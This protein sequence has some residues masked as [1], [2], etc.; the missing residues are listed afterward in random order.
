MS[1][2]GADSGRGVSG[3]L[4][5]MYADTTERSTLLVTLSPVSTSVS[6]A[7]IRVSTFSRSGC[8]REG[9]LLKE[10]LLVGGLEGAGEE[11]AEW[12]TAEPKLGS[13]KW[14][15]QCRPRHWKAS[16]C[17]CSGSSSSSQARGREAWE[18]WCPLGR[19]ATL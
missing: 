9:L 15:P 11:Q 13:E 1:S 5:L 17:C 8:V 2:G 19:D 14:E 3:R 4:D 10:Q 18:V 16:G 7:P 12:E 6:S